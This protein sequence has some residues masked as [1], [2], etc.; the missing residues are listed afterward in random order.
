MLWLVVILYWRNT[1]H[2]TGLQSPHSF[3]ILVLCWTYLFTVISFVF[4]SGRVAVNVQFISVLH[5]CFLL[6]SD[7]LYQFTVLHLCFIH[8][9]SC[10]GLVGALFQGM[11]LGM[12]P[13]QQHSVTVMPF[14]TVIMKVSFRASRHWWT[15][16]VVPGHDASHLSS[17][18]LLLL[19]W[20]F[21]FCPQC[22]RTIMDN[23]GWF[24]VIVVYCNDFF[25]SGLSASWQLQLVPGHVLLVFCY[26]C[27]Y[28]SIIFS[29]GVN[30]G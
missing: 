9:F 3:F 7:Y 21:Q 22:W 2:F 8:V 30:G 10:S 20:P 5:L 1:S 4:F 23:C 26:Y 11:V 17:L 28:C 14:F 19:H 27:Y 12:V 13:P 15:L 29:S 18:V 16:G 25:S 6:S 24:V